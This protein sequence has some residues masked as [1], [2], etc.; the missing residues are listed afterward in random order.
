M[1]NK[2]NRDKL[3]RFFFRRKIN[4]ATLLA[5]ALLSAAATLICHITGFIPGRL[6]IL[7]IVTLLLAA[8]CIVQAY[9]MRTSFRTMKDFKGKRKKKREESK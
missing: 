9:R 7:D 8:L 1:A 6:I 5:I 2:L 4:F 3:R